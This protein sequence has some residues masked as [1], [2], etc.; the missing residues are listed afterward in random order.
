T[1]MALVHGP[2]SFY[3]LR[4]LLGV[5]EAGF[6]PGIILYLTYW[7]PS[8]RRGQVT[9]M[10]MA[11]IPLS[12]LIGA[13]LSTG[14]MTLTHGLFGLSGWQAMY[15]IEGAPAILLGVVTWFYLVDRPSKAKW[16]T[17]E[18][19]A[20]LES[21]LEAEAEEASE[22]GQGKILHALTHP[23]ILSL[24]LIYVG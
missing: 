2:I 8:K 9:A 19:S 6:F 13:P 4:F 5:A 22:V 12:G 18:E 1:C 3:V 7:F 17:K 24:G 10:F 11:A 23:L 15:I 21:Q 16:L 14:L 20:W